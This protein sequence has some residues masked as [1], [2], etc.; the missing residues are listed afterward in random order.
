MGYPNQT[1]DVSKVLRHK[2]TI[3]IDEKKLKIKIKIYIN[4]SCP[5]MVL[6]FEIDFNLSKSTLH[7]TL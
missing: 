1:C 7:F 3:H 5:Q 6:H 2:Q 4:M